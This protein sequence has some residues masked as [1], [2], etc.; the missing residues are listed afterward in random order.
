MSPGGFKNPYVSNDKLASRDRSNSR[1]RNN[2]NNS[3]RF[4]APS[5]DGRRYGSRPNWWGN[6]Y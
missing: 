4:R 6:N 1:D 2:R 3:G 5:S